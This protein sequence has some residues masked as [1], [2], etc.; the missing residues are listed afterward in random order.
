MKTDPKIE[1]FWKEYLDSMP[2][3]TKTPEIYPEVWH[4][5]DNETDANELVNLVREG[6]K[7]ATCSLVWAYEAEGENIPQPGLISIITD[8]DGN[9]HCVIE[10]T[11]VQVTPF[12]DVDSVLARDEGEGDK[13]LDYWRKVHWDAFSRECS[14]LGRTPT[15]TMLV[16]C[17]RFRVLFSR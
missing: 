14:A 6:V 9:P 4:F 2:K 15:D 11:D 5:C 12:K 8:W 10:T 1:S 16:V 7:R 3:G 13:S 17:Q